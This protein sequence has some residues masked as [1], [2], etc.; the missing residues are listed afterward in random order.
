M[1]AFL[2]ESAR[3]SVLV[4]VSHPEVT[5][6]PELFGRF[7]DTTRVT[8]TQHRHPALL[9][10]EQ[11][12]CESDGR[13]VLVTGPVSGR[14]AADHLREHGALSSAEVIRWGVRICDAL[15]FLHAHG[16]VHGHL[17]PSTLFLDGPADAPEVRLLDT[18]LLLF[19]GTR[20][21]P[22]G[23]MLVP[24]E[25]LSPERC[26]GRRATRACDVYGMGVLLHEL[27][28]GAP[29]FS[30]EDVTATRALHLH[31]PLPPLRPGLEEWGPV[32]S[33]CLSKRPQD[34]FASLAELRET[35]RGLK[36]LETPAIEIDVKDVTAPRVAGLQPGD[37]VG[38]YRVERLIGEGGM[39]QV[40][41][42]SHLSIDRRVALK[43]LRPELARV[44]SQVQR[45]VAEAQAVNRVKHPHII[46]IE[47]LVQEGERIYF[48]ME[49]LRGKTLKVLAKEAPIELTRAVRLVRQAAQALAA[50]HGVGVIHRDVKPD[51]L[52]V[53][54]DAQGREQLK[55]LDFGV[56]RV[57]GL[58]VRAAYKTQV[59]QVVGTPLWMAPEQ[60]LGHEVDP[61]ADVY[62]LSMVLF[63]LLTRR[64]PFSGGDLSQV[65]MYRLSRDADPIGDA[66]FLGEQVPARLQRLLAMGLSRELAKR[67][68]S[69]S[70]MA[71]ELEA[72]EAELLS[73]TQIDQ[74]RRS[75]WQR[76]RA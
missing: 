48:V 46:A 8:T 11:T 47:D 43:V 76:W 3:G 21:V 23:Q 60:V 42:A 64:F 37:V 54:L 1:D 33:R 31:A 56:A 39:G 44:D 61:R 69:M 30:G 28:T 40:F 74:H 2:A 22:S 6:D 18:A 55:V 12:H 10:V 75:W 5:A 17:A 59:G 19:R 34:R 16:V 15:E 41:E 7:L 67:P 38:R 51:N 50:A 57:R 13:F 65:V 4:Q 36:P 20:S 66:T 25:Y 58:D 63:V 49:L 73:P 62:A 53:E 72:I 24:P 26:A 9:S 45:F 27:L 68:P 32:L 29:P 71:A 70:W 52:V 35:L 14:T